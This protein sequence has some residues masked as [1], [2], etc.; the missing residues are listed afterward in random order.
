M[1]TT[2]AYKPSE[3]TR[4]V[5]DQVLDNSYWHYFLM[6]ESDFIKT[7]QFVQLD[8]TN[9]QTYSLEFA[10]QL[11][12]ISSEFETIAKLLC[13]QINGSSAGN[14]EQYKKVI[15]QRYPK[16]A[17]TPV[18]IDQHKKMTI[19]P[20]KPWEHEGGKINWW[21]AYNNIKHE[22]HSYF[23]SATLEH[24][25]HALGSLLILESYLYCLAYP[26]PQNIQFG[27]KLI[28]VPGLAEPLYAQSGKLP[29]FES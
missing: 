25:L 21:N 29:D 24:T 1:G 3:L 18:H 9:F 6:L 7:L 22:R 12:C 13:K 19:Y 4:Y 10:K 11:I 8:E 15:L 23:Q 28:R 17:L 5:S 27:T 2:R 26:A 14:I 20:L 16:I